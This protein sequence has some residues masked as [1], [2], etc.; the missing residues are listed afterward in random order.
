MIV[1][2]RAKWDAMPDDLKKIIEKHGSSLAMESAR[3]REAQEAVARKKL[4]DN[5]YV[6]LLS[7]SDDR[8]AEMQAEFAKRE[9]AH[10]VTYQVTTPREAEALLQRLGR[11]EAAAS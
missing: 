6:T 1:M 3:I 7:F 8:R 10:L 9:Y 5:P 4:Q 2:N 11:E